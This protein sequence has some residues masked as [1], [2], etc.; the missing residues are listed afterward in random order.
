MAGCLGGLR[1]GSGW[2]L[3][4]RAG[5]LSPLLGGVGG[6]GL[7]SSSPA[8]LGRGLLLL[9]GWVLGFWLRL[10]PRALG[11]L[12]VRSG[13]GGLGLLGGFFRRCMGNLGPQRGVCVGGCNAR[14]SAQP[15]PFR[16]FSGCG[17]S[18]ET[19]LFGGVF[20]PRRVLTLT[21]LVWQL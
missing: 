14:P 13:P 17:V 16:G 4:A 15:L 8:A 21:E 20:F 19:G 5:G 18:V 2:F 6:V 12:L 9:V 11:P 3:L 10:V 7:G 1:G